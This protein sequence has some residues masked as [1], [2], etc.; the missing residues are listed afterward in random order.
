MLLKSFHG[1][2]MMK[3]AKIPKFVRQ[4]MEMAWQ[5]FTL[6]KCSKE[7]REEIWTHL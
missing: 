4:K 5:V 7:A 6:H 2:A 3:M 1:G